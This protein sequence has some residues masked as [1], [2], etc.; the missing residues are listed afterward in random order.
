MTVYR[1]EDRVPEIDSSCYIAPSADVI[2][3]VRM[4]AHASIWFNAVARGDND[5]ITIGEN[6]N[7]QDN[8]VLHT[9]PGIP[10]VIGNNVTVGHSVM[11]HGCRIGDDCLIGIG[12]IVLNQAQI[13]EQSIVGANT[14]V[15]EGKVF[16]PRS[17][18]VG[19]PGRIIRQ[20]SDEE[21]A[22]LALLADSYVRKISRYRTLTA[23]D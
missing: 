17:M 15:T 21:V 5:P 13:G 12:S 2:G 16:P 4:A 3:S 23:L 10:L 19:S 20:L 6:S 8:T 18:I 7:I 9:D 11:L 1:L 22:G 14:L